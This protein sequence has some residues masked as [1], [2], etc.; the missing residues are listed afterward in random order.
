MMHSLMFFRLVSFRSLF[1]RSLAL[2]AIGVAGFAAPAAAQ[3]Q[4]SPV[5]LYASKSYSEGAYLCAQ[6][7]LMLV[8]TVEAGR[9]TWKPVADKTIGGRCIG[10]I[11]RPEIERPR[12]YRRRHVHHISVTA[13]P[14][15]SSKCFQFNGK[16]YCE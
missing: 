16:R 3:E 10:D 8:C 14:E 2:L 12:P 9:A 15:T 7:E 11:V 4:S 5:C 1:V 13:P 6:R